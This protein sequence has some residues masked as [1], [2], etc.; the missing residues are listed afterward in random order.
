MV[1]MGAMIL[2]KPMP[3]PTTAKNQDI[4]HQSRMGGGG[5]PMVTTATTG[6]NM[7]RGKTILDQMMIAGGSLTI[8]GEGD[9]VRWIA[10]SGIHNAMVAQDMTE[11]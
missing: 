6:C 1:G 5:T 7:T 9:P 4:T 11:S 8:N 10:G 3:L 2:D